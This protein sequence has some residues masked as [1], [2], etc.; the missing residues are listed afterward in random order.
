MVKDKEAGRVLELLPKTARYYFTQAQ[1]P[2]ALAAD[3]L[4][5][6]ALDLG[7]SGAS[8]PDVNMALKNAMSKAEKNDLVLVCGSVFT[9]G[10]VLP[11]HT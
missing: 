8:F 3:Q 2:R 6:K 5:S 11:I 9:V 4:R 7:L 1:I 10:E